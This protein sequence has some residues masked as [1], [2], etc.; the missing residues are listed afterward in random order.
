MPVI[1]I[2]PG[3]DGAVAVLDDD[4]SLVWVWDTPTVTIKKPTGTKRMYKPAEM[5]TIL[6]CYK[7][8]NG[9]AIRVIMESVHAMPK[10]GGV[11]NFSMGRGVGCHS[12]TSL[13]RLGR[14]GRWGLAPAETNPSR[15]SPRSA[16]S[17]HP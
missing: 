12:S 10:Q 4:G 8:K 17:R 9:V 11:S 7:E 2:D 1:G 16:W 3:L 14:R 6:E 5:A 15:F 13:R